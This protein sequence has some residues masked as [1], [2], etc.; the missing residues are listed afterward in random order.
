MPS[1]HEDPIG[2]SY[3]SCQEVLPGMPFAYS[4]KSK[5][6]DNSL[7]LHQLYAANPICC[8]IIRIGSLKIEPQDQL[9]IPISFSKEAFSFQVHTNNGEDITINDCDI[10]WVLAYFGR[11]LPIM[12]FGCTPACGERLRTLLNL[13]KEEYDPSSK[14]EKP[15]YMTLLVDN[16]T[17]EHYNFL[18]HNFLL[19]KIRV[20]DRVKANEILVNSAPS[21]AKKCQVSET[22]PT[23]TAVPISISQ[24]EE[25]SGDVHKAESEQSKTKLQDRHECLGQ[26][27]M[28]HKFKAQPYYVKVKP[29]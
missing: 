9:F 18:R 24:N 4:Q 21:Q 29:A 5:G 16:F 11:Y 15:K 26:T 25:L 28:K 10:R 22:I 14:D 8:R 13:T 17:A 23:Q 6:S 7:I 19:Q 12:F 3:A 1:S 2:E 27:E 20:I